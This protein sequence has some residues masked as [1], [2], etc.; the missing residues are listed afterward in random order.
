[1]W[2]KTLSVSNCCCCLKFS[3]RCGDDISVQLYEQMS[4]Y[5][6]RYT[7]KKLIKV[8]LLSDGN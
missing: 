5:E 3:V 4:A 2:A 6:C 1:M 8:Q 7:L